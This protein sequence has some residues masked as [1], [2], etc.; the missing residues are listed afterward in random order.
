MSRRGPPCHSDDSAR[1][2]IR[3]LPPS[4]WSWAVI[5][6]CLGLCRW[7]QLAHLPSLLPS[8]A[9]FRDAW[10]EAIMLVS[11]E[12]MVRLCRTQAL[13]EGWWYPCERSNYGCWG[14]GKGLMYHGFS[15]ASLPKNDN[16]VYKNTLNPDCSTRIQ[17]AEA[18]NIQNCASQGWDHYPPV[19]REK[20]RSQWVIMVGGS[21]SWGKG[22]RWQYTF[23]G[24]VKSGA[25]VDINLYD[26][27]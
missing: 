5:H 10:R 16:L 2:A 26:L 27:I 25:I 20:W 15:S 22:R 14:G 6:H 3:V 13:V 11:H 7:C 12:Q 4:S 9:P 24:S 23:L 8:P 17:K 18:S 21:Q 1:L 19:I